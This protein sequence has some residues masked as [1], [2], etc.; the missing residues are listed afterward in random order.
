VHANV[1]NGILS[2]APALTIEGTDQQDS[3]AGSVRDI[4]DRN[5][6]SAFPSR[7]DWEPG[8][9]YV[10]IIGIG[11]MLSVIYPHL[12]PA[13]LAVSSITFMVGLTVLNFQLWSNYNL[14]ISLVIL[15][16]VLLITTVNMTYGFLREGLKQKVIKG[17]FDQYVPP[18]HIDAMLN[19]ST[20]CRSGAR[21]NRSVFISRCAPKPMHRSNWSRSS[22]TTTAH[23][24]TMQSRTGIRRSSCSGNCSNWTRRHSC[25]KFICSAL[26]NCGGRNC[27]KTGTECIVT[28]A[29]EAVVKAVESAIDRGIHVGKMRSLSATGE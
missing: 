27:Q 13:L 19:D 5:N 17:M 4:F 21:S 28:R 11:F 1:L 25:M 15:L 3:A 23:I 26:A 14:D 2:S 10:A 29:N 16:L 7:P 8:A 22:M 12:G 6:V 18:V 24:S 9:V 20:G